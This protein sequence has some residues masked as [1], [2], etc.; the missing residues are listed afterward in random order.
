MDD[1]LSGLDDIIA[2]HDQKNMSSDDEEEMVSPFLAPSPFDSSA[3]GGS[4]VPSSSSSSS[5]LPSA[6]PKEIDQYFFDQLSQFSIENPLVPES[7]SGSKG[8]QAPMIESP[9]VSLY[10]APSAPISNPFEGSFERGN[11]DEAV[12]VS[13]D[14]GA[15]LYDDPFF[16]PFA[17]FNTPNPSAP[18]SDD[19]FEMPI[20]SGPSPSASAPSGLSP[21]GPS[22]SSSSSSGPSPSSFGHS[23]SPSPS[24]STPAF[25]MPSSHKPRGGE[26][27]EVELTDEESSGDLGPSPFFEGRY[28]TGF[29]QITSTNLQAIRSKSGSSLENDQIK[30]LSLILVDPDFL[31]IHHLAKVLPSEEAPV[32]GRMLLVLMHAN[33]FVIPPMVSI[34]QKEIAEAHAP[35]LMFRSNNLTS[36]MMSSFTSILGSAYITNLAP[37]ITEIINK[38]E[39]L[40]VDPSRAASALVIEQN[41]N[42]ILAY[43][44]VMMEKLLCSIVDCPDE[45]FFVAQIMQIEVLSKFPDHPEYR[46][47]VVADFLFSR[48]V[49]TALVRPEDFNLYKPTAILPGMSTKSS[50]KPKIR[51][52]ARRTLAYLS[53]MLHSVVIGRKCTETYLRFMDIY[54]SDYHPKVIEFCSRLASPSH[55]YSPP[56]LA[57]QVYLNN[58]AMRHVFL[59]LKH[60]LVAL[61]MS[62]NSVPDRGQQLSQELKD[63]LKSLEERN[64]FASSLVSIRRYR[65]MRNAKLAGE[66]KAALAGAGVGLMVGGCVGTL[67]V[68]GVGTVVGAAVGASIGGGGVHQYGH[69]QKVKRE[70]EVFAS[71]MACVWDSFQH[72]HVC[73][74]CSSTFSV[75]NRKHHCRACGHVFCNSCSRKRTY[76]SGIMWQVRVCDQ[77]YILFPM[78]LNPKNPS[79]R[80][81]GRGDME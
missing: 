69:N 60:S 2:M 47:Q 59:S 53:K 68:P 56:T 36:H 50:A 18:A 70:K 26:E 24:P 25:S 45:F 42:K 34:V 3:G 32:I 8:N 4:S 73:Y 39:D 40:E 81:K 54:I 62:L 74:L 19:P 13:A 38:W 22:P 78:P 48:F 21:S 51:A 20:P 33:K 10:P 76:L 79:L 35:A 66:R 23:P 27:E 57:H 37:L 58:S 65:K 30:L 1:K 15:Q 11:L 64:A 12:V 28:T 6:P 43:G 61:Q 29:N 75:T 41:Q 7:D 5:G 67:L 17:I 9:S 55:P 31:I 16:D 80:R 63:V 14:V 44:M 72:T 49:C 52:L 46:H 71:E 77:C